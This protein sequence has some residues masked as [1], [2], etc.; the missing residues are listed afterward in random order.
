[1]QNLIFGLHSL[2]RWLVVAVG[3]AAIVIL[4]IRLA[5]KGSFDR[6]SRGLTAAFSGLIDLQFTLGLIYLSG[7]A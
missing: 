2:N 6:P 3:L 5:N 4:A 7:M 1:M